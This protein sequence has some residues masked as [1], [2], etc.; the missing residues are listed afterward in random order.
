M[1]VWL[2]V[3]LIAAAAKAFISISSHRK[4]E[5]STVLFVFSSRLGPCDKLTLL[6]VLQ[7]LEA[8]C[9]IYIII[10]S[11]AV[12]ILRLPVLQTHDLA[13]NMTT[14]IFCTRASSRWSL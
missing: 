11:T 13:R 5:V 4:M 3:L 12:S 6:P 9:S 8:M 10:V 2:P 14:L 1:I 7:S